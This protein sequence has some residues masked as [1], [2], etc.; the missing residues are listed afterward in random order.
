M[1]AEFEKKMKEGKSASR[2]RNLE[3]AAQDGRDVD[4]RMITTLIRLESKIDGAIEKMATRDDI[5]RLNE[6]M[7]GFSG[8]LLDSRQRWSVHADVLQRHD[9]RIADIEKRSA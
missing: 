2:L 5:S 8:L 3:Q 4:R 9:A 1:S 6:R 7:D